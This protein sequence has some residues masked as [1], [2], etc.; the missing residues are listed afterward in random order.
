M[1]LFLTCFVGEIKISV[2]ESYN[3]YR[4]NGSKGL[5]Y[6]SFSDKYVEFYILKLKDENKILRN[7]KN[8]FITIYRSLY[9]LNTKKRIHECYYYSKYSF[10]Y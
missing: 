2:T 7:K 10:S 3:L 8:N 6:C 9:I 4:S 1:F 5:D